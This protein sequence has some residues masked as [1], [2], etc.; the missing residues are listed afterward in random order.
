MLL[1][2]GII[3]DLSD[4]EIPLKCSK[5][6]LRGQKPQN[7]NLKSGIEFW[8]VLQTSQFYMRNYI[9]ISSCFLFTQNNHT[10]FH[11]S[12]IVDV[13]SKNG[14]FLQFLR[15]SPIYSEVRGQNIVFDQKWLKHIFT[16][17]LYIENIIRMNENISK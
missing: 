13:M 12:F 14:N 2:N 3:F 10:W 15:F 1:E 6:E 7:F 8:K 17:F 9:L 5:G 4:A 11:F 16:T